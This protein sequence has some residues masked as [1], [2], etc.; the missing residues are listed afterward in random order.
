MATISTTAED[1]GGRPPGA[2]P[3]STGDTA[4]LVGGVVGERCATCAA[5]LAS[6]Q[7]YCVQ[8][9]ERRGKARFPIT[10]T[11]AGTPD[12]QP[13]APA[14]HRAPPHRRVPSSATLVAGI[15]TLLLAMGVGVEIGRS[16]SSANPSPHAAGPAVQVVTVGGGGGAAA[17][18]STAPT[19]GSTA[20]K[21]ATKAPS[22]KPLP[23]KVVVKAQQA[24]SKVLGGQAP[25]QPTVQQGQSCSGGSS[26][27]CQNGKFTGQFFGP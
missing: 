1:D 12:P 27:G 13:A 16:G 2:D 4:Q 24:A 21:A 3:A 17:A 15:A 11:A 7:R 25:S 18:A 20:S 19:T 14:Q 23:K 9:G 8:C 22:A 26:S 10:A 5:P 6:D